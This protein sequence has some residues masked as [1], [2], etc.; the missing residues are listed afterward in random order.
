MFGSVL[1]YQR[2]EERFPAHAG[3]TPILGDDPHCRRGYRW[4]VG[5]GPRVLGKDKV[6]LCHVGMSDV[7]VGG[8]E[9][10]PQTGQLL[11]GEL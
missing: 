4:H 10:I 5:G 1:T 6:V 3:V 7:A 9:G 8:G 11:A 2:S